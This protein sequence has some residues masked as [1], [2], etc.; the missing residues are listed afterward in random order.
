MR[1][2]TVKAW[3]RARVSIM[4]CA[5]LAVG[6]AGVV[7]VMEN[8]SDAPSE[9]EFR[10]GSRLLSHGLEQEEA[11][12]TVDGEPVSLREFEAAMLRERLATIR[13]FQ[14]KYGAV[15]DQ[16]FWNRSYGGKT[17]LETLRQTALEQMIRL[18]VQQ[19]AAMREGV[20]QNIS[21]D[22]T[23]QKRGKENQEREAAVRSGK[24]IYG[25]VQYGEEEYFQ[26]TFSNMLTS[27][28]KHLAAS[29]L[30]LSPEEISLFYDENK[31]SLYQGVPMVRTRKLMFSDQTEGAAEK[32]RKASVQAKKL[33]SLEKAA[34]YMSGKGRLSV[35][36][37]DASSLRDDSRYE[38]KL[39][40]T[41][42]LLKPG[43]ISGAIT[44]SGGYAVLEGLERIE[45]GFVPQTEA[46]E[47]IR[48]RLLDRKYGE[49]LEDQVRHAQVEI[50]RSMF[51]KL[52]I[53]D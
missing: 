28:K 16:G 32:A 1:I 40:M 9:K 45:G 8:P 7:F 11:V 49:W 13:L 53:K 29:K 50:N 25:P 18:K 10:G 34:A 23:L 33:H 5:L 26:Y 6:M 48:S 24:V 31:E 15:Y 4:A 21:Y 44:V 22:R 41:A 51:E 30:A 46:V 12:L 36:V 39:L 47:D 35:Q 27:L 38:P 19:I 20:I 14:T 17:P 43:E 3:K 42:Q 2:F 52:E 37:F